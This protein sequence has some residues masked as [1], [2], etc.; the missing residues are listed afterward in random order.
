MGEKFLYIDDSGQLSNNG[1]HDYFIYSGIF[2]EDPNVIAEV[3]RR[4]NG[5]AKKNRIKGEFKG[6]ELG[7]RHRRALIKIMSEV[8]GLHQL[9]VI[10]K[11]ELLEKVDFNDKESIRFHKNYLI[12]RLIEKAIK[13]NWLNDKDTLHTYID[14]EASN[15]DNQSKQLI[16]HL[17]KY[18]NKSTRGYYMKH[19][20][21]GLLIPQC[22]ANITVKYIDSKIDRLIQLADIVAN[23]KYKRFCGKKGCHS[24]L[25]NVKSCLKLPYVFYSPKSYVYNL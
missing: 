14:N 6:A 13:K 12:R 1:T 4:V 20:D 3:K 5:L 19:L 10:E 25:L 16:E 24:E 7:G 2:V 17:N 22:N 15:D 9:I 21:H 11:N 23:S 8:D 18:W